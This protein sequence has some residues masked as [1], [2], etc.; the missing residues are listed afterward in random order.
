MEY[1]IEQYFNKFIVF[2]NKTELFTVRRRY[3]FAVINK[4]YSKKGLFLKTRAFE[5]FLWKRIKVTYQ[6]L[7][8]SVN[9]FS[10][11][12]NYLLK[13]HDDIFDVDLVGFYNSQYCFYY[14]GEI[15]GE[16]NKV[17]PVGLFL[18]PPIFEVKIDDKVVNENIAIFML[19]LLIIKL[20]DPYD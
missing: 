20:P 8:E 11:Q 7:S 14:N 3:T 5:F 19:I 16:A 12:N 10:E 17:S 4:F 13:I 2:A 1:K 9:I 15:C 18:T 6:C